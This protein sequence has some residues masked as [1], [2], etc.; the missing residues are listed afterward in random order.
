MNAALGCPECV[1]ARRRWL[2]IPL[3]VWLVGWAGTPSSWGLEIIQ[4][5]WGFEGQ[6]RRE[7]FN[8]L[9]VQLSN[10]GTTPFDGEIRLERIQG[11]DVVDAPM[12]ET[13][14]LAPGASRW[15][16]FSPWIDEVG[17]TKW[18]LVWGKDAKAQGSIPSP[19]GTNDRP[20]LVV[21]E[22]TGQI[23]RPN[24]AT[25]GF[26]EELFPRSV[27]ACAGLGGVILDH[28]PRWSEAQQRAFVDWIRLGGELHL[29]QGTAGR[30]PSLT[31]LLAVLDRR[32]GG[33]PLGAG[34]I[35]QHDLPLSAFDRETIRSRILQTSR[36]RL[37]SSNQSVAEPEP[38]PEGGGTLFS[39]QNLEVDDPLLRS[40]KQLTRAQH[41]WVLIHA[42]SLIFLT[43]V[44]PGG[45]WL[46]QWRRG[47]YR[48]MFGTLL[49]TIGLFSLIFLW[50]GRRGAGEATLV[51]SLMLAERIEAGRYRVSGWSNVFVTSGGDYELRHLGSGRM[52]S[53]GQSSESMRGIIRSG[54][55]AAL[56]T[57]MPAFSS[58][59][60]LS[61]MELTAPDMDVRIR[62]VRIGSAQATRYEFKSDRSFIKR[63]EAGSTLEDLELQLVTAVPTMKPLS[64]WAVFDQQ[65]YVLSVAG[66]AEEG[67][68]FIAR[69][70][71]SAQSL[72]QFFRVEEGLVGGLGNFGNYG[73]GMELD[74][75]M[76]YLEGMQKLMQRALDLQT[77]R[78]VLEF[79]SPADRIRVFLETELPREFWLQ[80]EQL[81]SQQ[82][83]CL[84]SVELLVESQQ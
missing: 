35:Q 34:R 45:W 62:K 64:A 78:D 77:S 28:E 61:R 31:G 54:A 39:N 83:R 33:E 27:T 25:G 43:L 63:T 21:L 68:G 6:V 76:V 55:E 41:S 22:Q 71:Q 4:Q 30:M 19:R 82:G 29:T 20:A 3:I 10:P 8:L 42:L 9:S 23:V 84:F 40:L 70:Q 74:R 13:L 38:V 58:R 5:K 37:D 11:F 26:A 24:V 53:S 67:G 50:V 47:D 51:D 48:L 15:V 7:Q 52:Y 57:D 56:I 1:I 59:T 16:Q 75:K 72:S 36:G 49:L 80:G 14:Y 32:G 17:F 65:L 73:Y 12:V 44:F 81:P 79:R 66:P 2:W 18:R 60:L 69:R 46:G